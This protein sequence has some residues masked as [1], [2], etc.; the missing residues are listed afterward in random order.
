MCD[1]VKRLDELPARERVA[2][3]EHWWVSHGITAGLPGWLV[4]SPRRHVSCLA[5]LTD[6]EAAEL[7]RWQ[8]RLS[9][10]LHAVT[11]CA[12]TYVAQFSE[13]EGFTHL[14]F[15][16]IPRP[17]ELS[18]ENRGPRVFGLLG[19]P[20]ERRVPAEGMDALARTLAAHLSGL[21]G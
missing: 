18:P 15:H 21:P 7:G 19:L 2:V 20:E 1:G 4:L 8:V 17:A 10:A 5:E 13:A 3:D 12:K 14:H 9:R 6:V 16:V 11:G